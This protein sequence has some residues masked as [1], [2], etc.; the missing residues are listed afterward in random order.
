MR[1]RGTITPV[2][3]VNHSSSF[4][5]HSSSFVNHSTPSTHA[6]A[7]ENHSTLAAHAHTVYRHLPEISGSLS[8]GLSQNLRMRLYARF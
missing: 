8:A 5:N 6:R 3:F 4:V 7:H 2:L 1:T